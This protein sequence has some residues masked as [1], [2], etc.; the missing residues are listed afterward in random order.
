MSKWISELQPD[1]D[2]Y[3]EYDTSGWL[4]PETIEKSLEL[5]KA[6]FSR[7]ICTG[8][9][10]WWFDLWGGWYDHEKISALF[11]EM[12]KAGNE[13]IH[14]PRSP[15]SEICVIVDERS[16]LCYATASQKSTWVGQ[17]ISQ[18]GRVGAPYDIYLHEDLS[19][20]DVSKYKMFVFLNSLF[21]TE[22]DRNMIRYKC[23]KDNR[24][25]LWFYAPGMID[26]NT[27]SVSNVSSLVNMRLSS[28]ESLSESEV[29]VNLPD[30]EMIYNGVKV[31]PFLYVTEGADTVY[32]QTKEGYPVLAEKSEQDYSNVLHA[33][34]LC[35]GILFSTLQ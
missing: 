20:L 16:L 10:H 2:P 22:E 9:T 11:R 25:L 15:V 27:I 28:K 18:I 35:H 1:V 4:G 29:Y 6:V 34:L 12:Q 31:S 24:L 7:V 23:M 17:Q 30:K 21:L 3:H 19:D 26:S 8:S 13:S 33:F 14:L 5:L 32:G